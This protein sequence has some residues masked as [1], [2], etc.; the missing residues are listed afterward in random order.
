MKEIWKTSLA[1]II[2]QNSDKVQKIQKYV[3]RQ[4]D[5]KSNP[6]INCDEVKNFNFLPWSESYIKKLF[7]KVKVSQDQINVLAKKSSNKA[8]MKNLKS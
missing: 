2:C 3:M 4:S 1:G 5:G 7:A 6:Y 8:N